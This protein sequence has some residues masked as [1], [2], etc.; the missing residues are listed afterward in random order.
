V[1]LP[2]EHRAAYLLDVARAHARA[3]DLPR[4]GRTLLAAE[5]AAPS[6]VRHRPAVRNLVAV[7]SRNADAPAELAQLA[8]ALHVA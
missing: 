2:P 1:G 7:V 8:A 3:G 6:E 4:A 5:R